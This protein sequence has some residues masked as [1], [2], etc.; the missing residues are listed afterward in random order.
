MS[1]T[2]RLAGPKLKDGYLSSPC[3]TVYTF[4]FH[5][6][7][8]ISFYCSIQST[9]KM[10]LINFSSVMIKLSENTTL[11]SYFMRGKLS[12]RQ[13]VRPA[14]DRTILALV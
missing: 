11:Y 6:G 3:S 2:S 8:L 13:V 4:F 1:T 14:V 7:N 10:L 5:L 9:R 12:Q